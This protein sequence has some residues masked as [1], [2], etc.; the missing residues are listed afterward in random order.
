MICVE[1]ISVV[2]TDVQT[3]MQL[4]IISCRKPSGYYGVLLS[5]LHARNC[6][7]C[8]ATQRRRGTH[9]TLGNAIEEGRRRI[10]AH[11]PRERERRQ[12]VLPPSRSLPPPLLSQCYRPFADQALD[13]G[14]W[15]GQRAT[16]TGGNM[17]RRCDWRDLLVVVSWRLLS[18]DP[19]RRRSCVAGSGMRSRGSRRGGGKELERARKQGIPSGQGSS[20]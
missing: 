2:Q 14:I 16:G 4:N 8:C 19:G 6:S 11:F 15:V 13:G 3:Y 9:K 5:R 20:C 10:I 12:C 1:Y 17:T 7:L 18:D